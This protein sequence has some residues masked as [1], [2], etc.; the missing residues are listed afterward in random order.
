MER[1]CQYS[2]SGEEGGKG[3][4]F[5]AFEFIGFQGL[6]LVSGLYKALVQVLKASTS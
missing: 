4:G 6:W 5:G 2:L 1:A 3:L